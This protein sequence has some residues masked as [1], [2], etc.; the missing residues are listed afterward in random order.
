MTSTRD[1]LY[2]EMQRAGFSKS[3]IDTAWPS[4]WTEEADASPSSRAELRFT[5]SRRLGLSP[6]AL[7]GERVEFFWDD[8]A[9]FKHLKV[10]NEREQSTIAS[11]GIAI[12]RLLIE[13]TPQDTGVKWQDLGAIGLREIILANRSYVDLQSLI[14]VCWSIGI[15]VIHLNVFPLEQKSMHAMVVQHNRRFAILLARNAQYPAPVAFTVAHELGHIFLGH[16][17][18]A[19]ALVDLDDPAQDHDDDPQEREA[20]DF[21]LQLLAGSSSLDI[22]ADRT[23]FNAPTLAKAVLDA[24]GQYR[25]EPGMLALALAYR[26]GSWAR[27]MSAL[28]FIYGQ[29]SSVAV[30]VNR[31]A[32]SN[33]NWGALPDESADYIERILADPDD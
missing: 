32:R 11:F 12:G 27:S 13:A 24:A 29:P 1:D 5:L 21:A 8:S 15:P 7:I 3:A 28:K 31:L 19:R 2:R 17:E 4:W 18:N 14:A 23:D 9:R 22:E 6:K 10:H 25:V 26:D 20:D 33:L 30:L 16:T